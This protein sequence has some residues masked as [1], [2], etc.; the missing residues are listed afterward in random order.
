MG[1]VIFLATYFPFYAVADS[2]IAPGSKNLAS[3]LPNVAFALSLNALATVEDA[4]IGLTSQSINNTY[5]NY[6]FSTGVS[7]M[8]FDFF[9]FTFLG[10][11]FN[12]GACS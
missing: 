3:L 1:T 4:G 11:Y 5:A 6:A 7:Y 10:F 12:N 8:F 9:L 2:T